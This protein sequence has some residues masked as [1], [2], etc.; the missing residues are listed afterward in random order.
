MIFIPSPHMF[1]RKA[2]AVC[3]FLCLSLPLFAYT[4]VIDAGHGGKD[5]GAVGAKLLEKDLN[6]DVAKRVSKLINEQHPEVKVLLTRNEDVYL[7]LQER[8][9]FVNK[10]H[11]DLF[12]SIHTNAAENRNMYGVETYVL[13]I[14]KMESNLDVA[15]RENAVITLE[16][17]YQTKYQGFDPNSVESYIMFEFMQDQYIDKSLS[18]ADLVQK[19]FVNG[20]NR[21][22]RGVRQAGFWVLHKSACPSVLIELGFL[23]HKQEE[24]YLATEQARKDLSNAIYSA[25]RNY[26]APQATPYIPKEEAKTQPNTTQ[27]NTNSSS[28]KTASVKPASS[29]DVAKKQDAKKPV[30]RV[31]IFS[32]KKILKPNDP[33]FK[34]LKNC[35]YTKDGEWYKYTYGNTTDY[36]EIL[37]IKKQVS[38]KFKDCFLVAFLGEEQIFVKDALKMIKK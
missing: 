26:Y 21:Y 6:L 37:R 23:S 38:T 14:H 1:V 30:F 22:D 12:I 5:P 27:K 15:M 31:Q 36:Q 7:T 11:A 20:L 2:F 32:S 33:T 4:V 9:N 13:G 28:N 17:D 3:L 19:Q 18:F 25:F 16:E 10:N 34:G 29:K 8:A 24:N 35:R